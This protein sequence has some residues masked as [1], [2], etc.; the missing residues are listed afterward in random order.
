MYHSMYILL[1]LKMALGHGKNNNF[2]NIVW[3]TSL[4]VKAF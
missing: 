4:G 1:T 2:L 3:N